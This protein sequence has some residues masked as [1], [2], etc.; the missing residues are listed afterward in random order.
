MYL[1]AF[2]FSHIFSSFDG[3]IYQSAGTSSYSHKV[4]YGMAN[5]KGK[6]LITGCENSSTCGVKTEL[7][8]I[9]TLE[10]SD[11]PDYPFTSE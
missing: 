5:Y 4:T 2:Q 6:A 1:Q 10:W 11:G 7:M 9:N 8:D 3:N